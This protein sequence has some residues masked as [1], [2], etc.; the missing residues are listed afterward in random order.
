MNLTTVASLL[1]GASAFCYT[2]AEI[3]I[4]GVKNIVDK[5]EIIITPAA[6]VLIEAEYKKDSIVTIEKFKDYEDVKFSDS[7][8][9]IHIKFKDGHIVP[10]YKIKPLK[11]SVYSKGYPVYSDEKKY[12]KVNIQNTNK[13]VRINDSLKIK[14]PQTEIKQ[15]L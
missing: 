6:P 1:F 9:S 12:I 15:R 14:L 3:A 8:I 2:T 4:H 5:R 11:D 10:N 7:L 13:A